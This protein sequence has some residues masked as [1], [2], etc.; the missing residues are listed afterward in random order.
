MVTSDAPI[1]GNIPVDPQWK[2]AIVRSIWYPE[3][4]SRLSSDATDALVAAGIARESISIID[5]PGSYEL[6]LLCKQALLSG[7]DGCIAFGIIVQGST[8]HAE[9][10]AEGAQQGIMQTQLELMKPIT[11]EVL[12]VNLLE[13]AQ[14]RS[15]GKNA[16]GGL[17]ASTLLTSLARLKELH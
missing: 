16:K 4:T 5:S 6:P 7:A 3:L 9:L 1:F 10:V 17:A 12:F 2:I 15:I 11:F 8:H 14:K 13:D